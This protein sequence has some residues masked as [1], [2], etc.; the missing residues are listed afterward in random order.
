LNKRFFLHLDAEHGVMC[1]HIK[2]DLIKY[3][4]IYCIKSKNKDK[5]LD[6]FHHYSYEIL[7]ESSPLTS[8]NLRHWYTL[9][10]C[11]EPEKDSEFSVYFSTRWMELLRI[12]LH[13]FLTIV[14]ASSSPPKLLLLEKWFRTDKQI[15]LRTQLKLLNDKIELIINRFEKYENRL[16]NCRETIR[17]LVNYIQNNLHMQQYSSSHRRQNSSSVATM[18]GSNTLFDDHDDHN[19]NNNNRQDGSQNSSISPTM[20]SKPFSIKRSET[21]SSSSSSSSRGNE[22][23]ALIKEIE[24][25]VS[26]I[27]AECARKTAILRNL[28]KEQRMKEILDDI[29]LL[30]SSS[31]SVNA[32]GSN[33]Q[34]IND[35]LHLS[36]GGGSLSGYS[37]MNTGNPP[38]GYVSSRKELED[39]ENDLVNKI[40]D[41]VSLLK[42][43]SSNTS[44]QH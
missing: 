43:N 9:P 35:F 18:S 33:S 7:S 37:S 30:N 42:S 3:Y 26:K 44:E 24:Q 40:Q 2:S 4:L 13:N 20:S 27:S 32:N 39:M 11:D 14:F 25:S 41:W 10:Y 31:T 5:I 23:A 36:S 8:G 29:Y 34:D 1:A 12:T 19:N 22:K 15:E 6:F 21:S 38:V 28:S 16:Q 17:T